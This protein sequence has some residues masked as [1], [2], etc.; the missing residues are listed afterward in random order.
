MRQQLQQQFERGGVGEAHCTT[1]V[2]YKA[3]HMLC[4]A[5]LRASIMGIDGH[6]QV[7]KREC[8]P[9]RSCIMD[10]VNN[11]LADAYFM[12]SVTMSHVDKLHC[13]DC[14]C[15]VLK[16]HFSAIHHLW[17]RPLQAATAAT[18]VFQASG[19]HPVV[20]R[21]QKHIL[22]CGPLHH[23]FT[24]RKALSDARALSML[25][26]RS[27]TAPTC[28]FKLDS[29]D[30]SRCRSPCEQRNAANCQWCLPLFQI[31]CTVATC[32]FRLDS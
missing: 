31:A 28:C 17:R 29:W 23:S 3:V 24:C 18:T 11:M 25:L 27:C 26:M 21:M 9:L 20:H 7:A 8:M 32:C 22:T 4:R 10:G 16:R 19:S 12:Q 14:C 2:V 5:D 13:L 6:H 1:G 30:S 15:T